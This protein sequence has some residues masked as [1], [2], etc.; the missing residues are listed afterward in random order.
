MET[1]AGKKIKN[2]LTNISDSDI[3]IPESDISEF[4]ILFPSIP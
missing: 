4:V 1:F 2:H 3:L